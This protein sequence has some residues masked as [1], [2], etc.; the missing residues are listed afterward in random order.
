MTLLVVEKIPGAFTSATSNVIPIAT[1]L[2]AT[3]R[4]VIAI[5]KASTSGSATVTGRG[6]T[7]VIHVNRIADLDIRVVS[8][9]GMTGVGSIT[10]NGVAVNDIYTVYVLRSTL[11]AVTPFLAAATD[12]GSNGPVVSGSVVTA[13]S[14]AA[15]ASSLAIAVGMG[16]NDFPHSASAPAPGS[17][18]VDKASTAPK[19]KVISQMFTDGAA[20][21]PT[22]R[23]DAIS[24]AAL[25]VAI[26][27]DGD[28]PPA[29]AQGVWGM[30][31][32][33]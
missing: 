2:E 21:S 23:T 11:T 29:P 18:T 13:P 10:V 14:L 22:I 33:A 7:W 8:A 24:Y 19:G 28:S 26:F 9:A 16:S 5:G 17:W 27:T 4:V 1:N 20:V 31:I 15:P 12:A 30:P 32:A 6:A 3:D 25:G